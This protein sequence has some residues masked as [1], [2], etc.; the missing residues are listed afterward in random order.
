M[1]R[2]YTKKTQ[3]NV[4][5]V[6]IINVSDTHQVVPIIW[7]DAEALAVSPTVISL[8]CTKEAI[9]IIGST[10]TAELGAL[11]PGFLPVTN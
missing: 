7:L 6:S 3:Q 2:R 11:E 1:S 4:T 8:V 5:P 10:P 9:Q